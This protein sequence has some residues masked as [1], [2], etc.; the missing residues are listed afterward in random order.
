MRVPIASFVALLGLYLVAARGVDIAPPPEPARHEAAMPSHAAR[1]P[2][3]AVIVDR[4]EMCAPG[5]RE[6]SRRAARG[7]HVDAA[8]KDRL[9]RF[10]RRQVCSGR[11]SMIEAEA[12]IASN[13]RAAYRKYFDKP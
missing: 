5:D 3:K 1:T 10:L 9:E 7:R 8:E 6:P 13:W 4:D 12:A 2:R 11:L